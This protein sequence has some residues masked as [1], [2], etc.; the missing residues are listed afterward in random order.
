MKDETIPEGPWR[1]DE[2][3]TAVFEDMLARSIPGYD[4][5]RSLVP[6]IALDALDTGHAPPFVVV[7]LGASRGDALASFPDSVRVAVEVS[8]PML[9]VLRARGFDEVISWDLRSGY[10][11]TK[12]VEYVDVVLLV[13][14][15]QFVPVE[16]RAKLLEGIYRALRVG[17]VLVVVEKVLPRG[18]FLTDAYRR[19][20]LEAGYLAEAIDRKALALEGVLVPLPVDANVRQLQDAG[21]DVE[22]F[23][24]DLVFVG[25]V[26]RKKARA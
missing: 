3:V 14:T 10:P 11:S 6:S 19:H 15:L 22:E 13:L 26:A 2:G 24:R 1:F 16:H 18:R 25:W 17:G 12:S 9:S 20:K 5:M 8:E 4:R 7:D 21:F 23:W